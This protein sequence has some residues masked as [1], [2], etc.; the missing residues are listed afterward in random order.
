M[1]CDVVLCAFSVCVREA[2]VS[3]E[4]GEDGEIAIEIGEEVVT[5]GISAVLIL[6]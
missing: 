4:E 5:K 1:A 2:V 6:V 3:R